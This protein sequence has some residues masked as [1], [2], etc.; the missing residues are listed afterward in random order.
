M[1]KFNEFLKEASDE[2]VAV[3]VFSL[4]VYDTSDDSAALAKALDGLYL[5]A[6]EEY[7]MR[8]LDSKR[9]MRGE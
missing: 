9:F 6:M 1:D 3:L 5:P 4:E 8:G 7:S 2:Q